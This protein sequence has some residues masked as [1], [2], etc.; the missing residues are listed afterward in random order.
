MKGKTMKITLEIETENAAFEGSA[1]HDE[2]ARILRA[3]AKRI[4]CG[5]KA[6]AI[7]DVNGNT[8]GAVEVED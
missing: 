4:E 3:A 1:W 8:V 2:T 6:F 5:A 7:I